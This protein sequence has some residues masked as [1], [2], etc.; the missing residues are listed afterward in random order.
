M[1]TIYFDLDGTL[2]DLYAVK[3]WLEKISSGD[4][5]PFREARPMIQMNQ[6]SRLVN[7]LQGE[8]HKVGI[9]SW[10]PMGCSPEFAEEVR[11]EKKRWLARRA[12]SIAWDEI[13]LVKYGTPK[14][15]CCRDINGVIF[16][17]NEKVRETWRGKAFDEKQ[18]LDILK[19]LL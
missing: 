7:L 10:L 14:H 16:D 6:L 5:T 3:E 17:D 13:H 2:A 11:K 12:T 18:I 4:P 1:S 9:I 8:G 19:Q 15:S